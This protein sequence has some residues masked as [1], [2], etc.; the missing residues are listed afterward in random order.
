MKD[1]SGNAPRFIRTTLNC[2]QLE[3]RTNPSSNISVAFSGGNLVVTGGVASHQYIVEENA[4]GDILVIGQNGTTVNGASQI[5]F[6]RINLK[7][8]SIND[9]NGNNRITVIGVDV[10]GTVAVAT[11][12]GNDWVTLDD[13]EAANISVHES[14]GN[15]TL[16]TTSVI[17]LNSAVID[18]G[19]GYNI[20]YDNR[21]MAGISLSK[22]G[23]DKI[24]T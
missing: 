24:D 5:N 15:N 10:P 16:E 11:G 4:A 3:L 17:A 18:S 1:A 6:G 8:L 9:G 19:N 22:K 12:N 7:N 13:I 23:W 20:W 14:G 21:L 2:E